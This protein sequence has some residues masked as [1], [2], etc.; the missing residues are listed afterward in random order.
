MQL[1]DFGGQERLRFLLS[2]YVKGATEALLLHDLTNPTS[3]KNANEWVEL[4]RKYNDNLPIILVGT[5]YDLAVPEIIDDTTSNLVVNKY[6]LIA[7]IKTSSKTGKNVEEVFNLL[8]NNLLKN[9]KID[10]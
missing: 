8:F 9:L 6:D 10:S 7:K 2:K 4:V 5:K 1:W 3:I